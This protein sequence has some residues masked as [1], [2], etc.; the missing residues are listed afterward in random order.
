MDVLADQS[1]PG[2]QENHTD[3]RL[4]ACH[5]GELIRIALDIVCV[6]C[7]T[8]ALRYRTAHHF[9]EHALESVESHLPSLLSTAKGK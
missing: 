2:P 3:W 9:A 5:L 4:N 1:I 7:V 6:R 8:C